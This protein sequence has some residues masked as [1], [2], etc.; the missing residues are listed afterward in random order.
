MWPR[1]PFFAILTI[2]AVFLAGL[3]AC[4]A[5]PSPEAATPVA[6]PVPEVAR[7][8]A[9]AGP[10]VRAFAVPE[11]GPIAVSP[12]DPSWGD[13]TALVTI[14][15]VGDF[16]CPFCARASATLE[17]LKRDY[18]PDKLR[19]VW[20]HLPLPF[21]PEARPS[22][23]AAAAVMLA[24]G[25]EAFWKFHD[26]IY[27]SQLSLTGAPYED[28]AREV[29]VDAGAMRRAI[30]SG[31]AAA[32]VDADVALAASIGATSTPTFFINGVLLS[33]AQPV[34]R[35]KVSIDAELLKARAKL[36]AGV[37]R[38]K[39]FGVLAKE[40]FSA[41]SR[42][43]KRDDDDDT[44]DK[45]YRVP[46]AG[47]PSK[48]PSGALVTVVIF[49]DFQCPFCQRAL[50]TLAEL[51]ARYA[52]QLR[53]V[54]K[55]LPLSFHK[56]A[57]PAAELAREARAQKGD[58]GFWKAHD[59]LFASQSTLEDADLERL[60]S[61]LSLDAKKV[62]AA[63]QK[64][65]HKAAI[66]ADMALAEDFAV[67]GTPHFFINGRR[68]VGAQPVEKFAAVVDLELARAKGVLAKG[69]APGDIYA[70]VTKDGQGPS[71]PEKRTIKV[72][73]AAPAA[74]SPKAPVTIYEFSDFQCP[75]CERVGPTLTELKKAYGARV[76]VVWRNL[77]LPFH[78]DAHLA[79]QAALE[80][81]AQ[82]G[83][84]AFWK[85]HD[86]LFENQRGEGL[87]RPQLMEYAAKLG[88]DGKRFGEALDGGKHKARVDEDAQAAAQANI[89]GTP[90]FVITSDAPAAD[91]TVAGYMLSGAQPLGKF[92]K[93]VER[94][95]SDASKK[96]PE[97]GAPKAAEGPR[98]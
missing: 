8:S 84:A 95:L 55:D 91:G 2:V 35:F 18:G 74:G 28:W 29:G 5:P 56:R 45:I 59:K 34:E 92:K 62:L 75:F 61:E 82:K 33:G 49:S 96:R 21:H 12:A 32:K 93:L 11:E 6:V 37:P 30:S 80:A 9:G 25:S 64:H 20:K 71:E 26:K 47:S 77:P 10:G 4:G 87:K 69:A 83:D 40:N 46:V 94:A 36:E 1:S 90:A 13:R 57:E 43:P 52:G 23:E 97:R 42:A 98:H 66:D 15:A 85:M 19:I 78:S 72:M 58:E 41:P 27:S 31:A 65:K 88:L 76:R 67:Q 50:A 39:L 16:Q 38:D 17:A 44:D 22:A 24:A 81:Q 73:A 86:L 63:I 14:V 60:A 68:L 48:G 7:G 79:A 89:S 70:A 54:W 53:F 3:S 51:D